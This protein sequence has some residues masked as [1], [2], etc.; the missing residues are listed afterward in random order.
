MELANL[1]V[2][3]KSLARQ[4]EIK[5]RIAAIKSSRASLKAAL[6]KW[7]DDFS[8][9]HGKP[10]SDSDKAPVKDKFQARAD[11]EREAAALKTELES[12]KSGE[13]P[14]QPFAASEPPPPLSSLAS[15]DTKGNKFS[16]ENMRARR[17]QW[18]M[19]KLDSVT[20]LLNA[21]DSELL[22]VPKPATTAK[23][24]WSMLRAVADIDTSKQANESA[25]TP[26]IK[27]DLPP[28]VTQEQLDA[29][30]LGSLSTAPLQ[31]A[32]DF[33]RSPSI[34]LPPPPPKTFLRIVK[35][36]L[37]T[38]SL[39]P[40]VEEFEAVAPKSELVV[41]KVPVSEL[42]RR[43][44]EVSEPNKSEPAPAQPV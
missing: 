36:D 4:K 3:K 34:P 18:S 43:E 17:K 2:Q 10:P 31:T 13:P 33:L 41:T 7:I 22:G 21:D 15:P 42:K 40:Y 9:S 25:P 8:S 24:R 16:L 26:A 20:A 5:K 32:E 28:G 19:N 39:T 12:L 37:T 11:L 35:E 30:S 27:L 23:S 44:E 38:P 29:F 14:F 6:K 1:V